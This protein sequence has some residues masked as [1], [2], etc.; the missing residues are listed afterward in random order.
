MSTIAKGAFAAIIARLQTI[1]VVSGY[2][3]DAGN[4]VSAGIRYGQ[5]DTTFPWLAVFSGDEVVEKKTINTYR[6]ERTVNIEAYVQDAST[7]TISI[8]ELIEDVQQAMEQSDI[9]LGGLVEV[10]DYTG[11]EEIE[12]PAAGSNIASVRI[13]YL[14][15]YQRAYGA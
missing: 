9:S 2:N 11:I 5:D 6:S 13:T 8:E 10:L 1:L 15:S 12:M 14:I 4:Q 7:P 3:T